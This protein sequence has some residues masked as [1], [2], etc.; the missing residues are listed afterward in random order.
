MHRIF[1][2][3]GKTAAL[4]HLGLELEPELELHTIRSPPARPYA[5]PS[6]WADAGQQRSLCALGGEIERSRGEKEGHYKMTRGK[7]R[8]RADVGGAGTRTA[9]QP[10]SN[11]NLSTP[12]P[13]NKPSKNNGQAWVGLSAKC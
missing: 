7:G 6:A 10:Q 8:T 13:C 12:S 4:R 11:V 9:Q 3:G 2:L 5:F 1:I